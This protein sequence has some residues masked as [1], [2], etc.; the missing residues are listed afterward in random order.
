MESYEAINLET[1]TTKQF[2]I[3]LQT[4]EAVPGGKTGKVISYVS[5]YNPKTNELGT[6][7]VIREN[8]FTTPSFAEA[9]ELAR[10]ISKQNDELLQ[11]NILRMTRTLTTEIDEV[12]QIESRPK[13]GVEIAY[14]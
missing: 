8:S 3:Q 14:N 6:S 4:E 12:A 13:G 1:Q 11:V 5:D 9:K 2:V 10:E 7:K